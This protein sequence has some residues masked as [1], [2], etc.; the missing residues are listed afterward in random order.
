M[1]RRLKNPPRKLCNIRR[2]GASA[3]AALNENEEILIGPSVQTTESARQAQAISCQAT[4]SL[5]CELGSMPRSQLDSARVQL[6]TS[7][8]TSMY[9]IR[10]K[11][12]SATWRRRANTGVDI[13]HDFQAKAVVSRVM[14]LQLARC[15]MHFCVRRTPNFIPIPEARHPSSYDLRCFPSDAGTC[16]GSV[17]YF[18]TLESILFI[19]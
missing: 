16:P 17:F 14:D 3:A 10:N 12:A 13:R 6:Q 2:G 18:W 11:C 7:L 9:H 19:I 8:P 5:G 15:A 1:L 4:L